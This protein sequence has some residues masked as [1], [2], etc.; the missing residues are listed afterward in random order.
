MFFEE[1]EITGQ[2]GAFHLSYCVRGLAET[3]ATVLD[4]SYSLGL[5]NMK[6][7]TIV[8]SRIISKAPLI[9]Y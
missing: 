7:V 8:L 9:T 4:C 3:E 2:G 5:S 6:T 1:E